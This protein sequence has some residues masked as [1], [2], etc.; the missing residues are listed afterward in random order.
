MR[1]FIAINSRAI[2]K[3]IF[4]VKRVSSMNDWDNIYD[5]VGRTS[6]DETFEKHGV[7]YGDRAI[8]LKRGLFQKKRAKELVLDKSFKI[9]RFSS[10]HGVHISSEYFDDVNSA[11][12]DTQINSDPFFEVGAGLIN[13]R[14]AAKFYDNLCMNN[15]MDNYIAALKEFF[16][17]E[18]EDPQSSKLVMEIRR[19]YH[20]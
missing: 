16:H 2:T 19:N 17:F 18:S 1:R 4:T 13:E 14:E 15:Q 3:G 9:S 6:I 5:E 12:I 8:I 10:V 20:D 7:P 11:T